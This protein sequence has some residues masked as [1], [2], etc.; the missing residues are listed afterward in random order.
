MSPTSFL[1]QQVGLGSIDS[2][3]LWTPN[4]AVSGNRIYDS[5]EFQVRRGQSLN[6]SYLKPFHPLRKRQYQ[7]DATLITKKI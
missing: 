5:E 6:P 2:N 7:R 3:S 4:L 1:G